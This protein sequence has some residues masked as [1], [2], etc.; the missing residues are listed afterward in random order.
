MPARLILSACLLGGWALPAAGQDAKP[1][2]TRQQE[3]Q[4]T[5]E[6]FLQQYCFDC[7]GDGS[8]KGNLSLDHTEMG[9]HHLGNQDLWLRIWKNLRTDL[10]PPSEKDQPMAAKRQEVVEWIEQNIFLLDPAKPDPG[11]ITMRRLNRVEYAHTIKDLLDVDYDVSQHFPPDDT[12]YGFDTIGD[13]L[14]ISTL[15]LE[16][17][18]AAAE[19]ITARALPEETNPAKPKSFQPGEFRQKGNNSRTARFMRAGQ[20]HRV[21]RSWTIDPAGKYQLTVTY[22]VASRPSAQGV[23]A[24]WKILVDDEEKA[25]REIA[26]NNGAARSVTVDL[27]LAAG[28]HRLEFEMIPDAKSNDPNVS[29]AVKVLKVETSAPAGVLPWESYPKSYR[30]V[31][32]KGPPPKDATKREPFAREVLEHFVTR[33]WRRPPDT[34]TI[35]QLLA[36]AKSKWE[37]QSLASFEAGIRYA[38][39]A[40]LSSPPFLLRGELPSKSQEHSL[41]IDDYALATRLSYFLWCSPPDE[42]LLKAA[43]E[44]TL[45]KSLSATIDRMLADPK[46]D[47]FVRH[48]VGQWLGTK[49]LPSLFFDT[50]QVIGTKN[51]NYAR[52]VFNLYTRQ[53]MQRETELFVAHLLRENRPAVELITADY[54]FINDRLAKFYG[55]PNVSGKQFRKVTLTNPKRPGGLLTQGSFLI[56]TSNPTRTSPVKRGL[57]VLD[58]LLGVPPPP[59]PAVVPDLEE[60]R[61][62]VGETSSMREAMARHRADPKCHS[63]HARMDP[64]GLALENY[65]AIGQW[66]DQESGKAIDTSGVLVTGEK[67]QGVPEL[68]KI[69]AGARRQDFYRCLTEKLLT[70]SL[71]RGI[72]PSDAPIVRGIIARSEKAGGGLRD[73]IEEIVQSVPFQRQ[74]GRTT[75]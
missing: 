52:Q 10:M 7:H 36:L 55:V 30:L 64:I 38:L 60:A 9:A 71:G 34:E 15:H 18:F 4:K 49:N 6:P 59:A 44:G 22:Q 42:Q 67:F 37:D 45:R 57:F 5:I 32:S 19:I 31:F 75:E 48:F 46:A 65:N 54:A 3:Y 61:R 16:K 29:L 2:E 63:C 43:Q 11:R 41:P 17:Y 14:S 1:L 69:I 53:D 26:I 70:Y 24:H 21:G 8:S 20:K 50:P 12:G 23:T 56:A 13:V 47:R 66:R 68:R 25:K 74:R 51:E 27:E 39:T 35:D 28:E 40:V 72:E 73:F 33:A 58:N 62:E